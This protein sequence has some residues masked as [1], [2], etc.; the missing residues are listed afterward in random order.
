MATVAFI[1]QGLPAPGQVLGSSAGRVGAQILLDLV[2]QSRPKMG[3][4]IVSSIV[5][6]HDEKEEIGSEDR[7][8]V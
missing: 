2:D 3:I 1:E 6:C 7:H 5:L 4:C 8:E